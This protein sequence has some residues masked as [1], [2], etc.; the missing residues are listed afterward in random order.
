MGPRSYLQ[1]T[2]LLIYITGPAQN[3]YLPRK[4]ILDLMNIHAAGGWKFRRATAPF[5]AEGEL[6]NRNSSVAENM[7]NT[8][9][10]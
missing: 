6:K 3:I 4:E 8:L 1:P 9:I 7:A 2:L 5:P 10:E